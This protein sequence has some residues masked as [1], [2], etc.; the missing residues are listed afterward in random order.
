MRRSLVL[1]LWRYSLLPSL[2]LITGDLDLS[3]MTVAY[4]VVIASAG[5]GLG[6]PWH[7]VPGETSPQLP[8]AATLSEP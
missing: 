2:R 1:L 4:Y 3:P 5:P 6:K 8:P 7:G